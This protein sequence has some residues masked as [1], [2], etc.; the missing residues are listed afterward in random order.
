MRPD[1]VFCFEVRSRSAEP[2]QDRQSRATRSQGCI[3]KGNR[4][5]KHC[6]DAV[7]GKSLNDPALR[8]H[9]SV[10]QFG[11]TAHKGEGGFLS[12]P[13][14]ERGEVHHIREQN[15]DLSAVQLPRSPSEGGEA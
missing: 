15:S 9:G 13:F 3:L 2:L 7:A 10:H 11:Q 1:T 12:P 5:T 6:H 8:A 4:G 14:R